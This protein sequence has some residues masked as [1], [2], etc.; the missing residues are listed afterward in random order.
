[1]VNKTISYEGSAGNWWWRAKNSLDCQIGQLVVLPEQGRLLSV[2]IRVA[3][4]D[5]NDPVY[6][7]QNE[8]GYVRA[9]VWDE[10]SG[11]V[12]AHS[13]TRVLPSSPGGTQPWVNF[14]LPDTLV[15]AGTRLIVGFWRRSDSTAY[16]TQFDRDMTA[17][18]QKMYRHHVFGSG[19]GPFRFHVSD[20]IDDASINYRLLYETGGRV[21][22]WD[23]SRWTPKNVNVWDGTDWTKGTVHVWDGSDWVESGE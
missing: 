8:S 18:G 11:D 12:I 10:R 17:N 14:D 3:G 13:S 23:G 16:S 20:T 22:V 15:D 7:Y 9:A 6:G 19:S 4:L 21:T 1:M 2:Q 5:Y